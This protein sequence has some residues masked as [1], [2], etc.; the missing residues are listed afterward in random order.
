MAYD[1][2]LADRLRSLL[3]ADGPGQDHVR[4]RR[5]FGGLAFLVDEHMAVAVSGGGGLMVRCDPADAEQHVQRDGVARMVMKERAMD[6][7]LLVAPDVLTT[8]EALRPWVDVG[9]SYVAG[10]PPK[11]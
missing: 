10:L 7:W 9:L 8:D 1:E 4:E 3:G 2:E 6:G 11:S 5:M